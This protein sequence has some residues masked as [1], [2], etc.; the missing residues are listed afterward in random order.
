MIVLCMENSCSVHTIKNKPIVNH[1]DGNKLNNNVLNLEWTT[2]KENSYHAY[3]LGLLNIG[4]NQT[5]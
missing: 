2:F 3:N 5:G 1:I 4:T